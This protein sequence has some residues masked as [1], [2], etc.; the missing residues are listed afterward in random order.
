MVEPMPGEKGD[1]E[2]RGRRTWMGEDCD[3]RGWCTPWCR[4]GRMR[5]RQGSNLGKGG[6]VG[7]SSAANY[8]N[9]KGT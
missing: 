4:E 1:V 9:M 8:S 3:W 2:W 7:E 6:Q 5:K